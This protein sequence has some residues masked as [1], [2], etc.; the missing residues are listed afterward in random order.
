MAEEVHQKR[1][2]EFLAELTRVINCHSKKRSFDA[3]LYQF[4]VISPD[5]LL[6]VVH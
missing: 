1:V 3:F 6:G 2:A 5:R 4:L